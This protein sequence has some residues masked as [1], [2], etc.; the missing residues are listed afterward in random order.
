MIGAPAVIAS[1]APPAP[2]APAAPLPVGDWQFWVV[3]LLA[4][5]A[6]GWLLR[7]VLPIPALRARLRRNKQAKRATLTIDGRT[8][9]R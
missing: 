2:S 1:D 5:I 4:I 3:T 7:G 8:I 9:G 6:A